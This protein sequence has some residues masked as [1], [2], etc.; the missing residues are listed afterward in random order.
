MFK[1]FYFKTSK[2]LVT[3]KKHM[4]IIFKLVNFKMFKDIKYFDYNL[5]REHFFFFFGLFLL[6]IESNI[7]SF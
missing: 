6:N 1:N 4:I 2:E 3:K 7:I 5:E